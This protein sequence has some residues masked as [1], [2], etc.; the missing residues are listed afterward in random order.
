MLRVRTFLVVLL[1]VFVV[2]FVSRINI[3]NNSFVLDDFVLIVNNSFIQSTQ[4]FFT[5][6][7]PINFF[8]VLPIRCGARPIT[9]A[10]YIVDYLYGI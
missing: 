6:I 8:K 7:N 10:T 3:L 9:V 2:S 5:V 4:N 1:F